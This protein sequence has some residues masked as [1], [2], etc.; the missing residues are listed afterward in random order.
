MLL[1]VLIIFFYEI[2]VVIIIFMTIFNDIHDVLINRC[3]LSL[4]FFSESWNLWY[5]IKFAGAGTT[6]YS[7]KKK[8]M[9]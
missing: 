8:A 9:L 3:G 1:V 4:K 2:D 6:S 5:G 7:K